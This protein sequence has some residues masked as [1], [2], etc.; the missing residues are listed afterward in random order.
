MKAIEHY[1]E[2][3][4]YVKINDYDIANKAIESNGYNIKYLDDE[5]K[6]NKELALKSV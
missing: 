5:F 3:V 1:G 4:K 2:N 6:N